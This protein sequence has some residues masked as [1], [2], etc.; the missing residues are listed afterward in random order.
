MIWEDRGV[1][2]QDPKQEHTT[3]Q[4]TVRV[5]RAPRYGVFM[6]L[7]ATIFALAGGIYAS[8]VEPGTQVDGR[9]IDTSPVIGFTIVA[10]FVIGTGVGALVA[11]LLDFFVGRKAH[12]AEVERTSVTTQYPDAEL[13]QNDPADVAEAA[14]VTGASVSPPAPEKKP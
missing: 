2:D 13:D 8:M 1:T 4:Q 6:A 3:E 12:A 7:G 10:G 9:I 5:R 14:D 11:V